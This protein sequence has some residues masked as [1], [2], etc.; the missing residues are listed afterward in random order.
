MERFG[1]GIARREQRNDIGEGEES[2]NLDFAVNVLYHMK[3]ISEFRCTS[4]YNN[5]L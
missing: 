4:S 3:Q 5:H 1:K 2:Q